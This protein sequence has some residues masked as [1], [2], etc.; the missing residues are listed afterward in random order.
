MYLNSKVKGLRTI[1]WSMFFVVFFVITLSIY[2]TFDVCY[3]IIND[4]IRLS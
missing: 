4:E 1:V 3:L 2:V